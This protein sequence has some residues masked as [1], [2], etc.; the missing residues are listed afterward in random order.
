MTAAA[1]TSCSPPKRAA[2]TMNTERKDTD[3]P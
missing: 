1:L 3:G 2:G